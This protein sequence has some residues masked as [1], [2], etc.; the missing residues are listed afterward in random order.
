MLV[1]EAGSTQHGHLY[2]YE[3][4]IQVGLVDSG[5]TKRTKGVS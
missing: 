2:E 3:T 1:F 5:L 4:E